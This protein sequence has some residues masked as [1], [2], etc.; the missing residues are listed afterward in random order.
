MLKM[1]ANTYNY[2]ETEDDVDNFRSM[3]FGLFGRNFP[4]TTCIT[5]LTLG[6]REYFPVTGRIEKSVETITEYGADGSSLVKETDFSY[7]PVFL[8]LK[9]VA[10]TNSKGQRLSTRFYYPYDYPVGNAILSMKASGIISP[11]IATEVWLEDAT[12]NWLTNGSIVDYGS[13]GNNIIR[14]SRSYSMRSAAPVPQS[15]IGDFNPALLNRNPQYF[16]PENS[17]DQY[18][19]KGNIAQFETRSTPG[20]IIWDVNG[21]YPVAKVEGAGITSI[22][23]CGFEADGTGNWSVGSVLRNPVGITGSKSYQLVNGTISYNGTL[24]TGAAYT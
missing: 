19:N 18:D 11:T 20:S 9:S 16:L 6:Y 3:K 15:A 23:Y 4:P 8:N 2:I 5:P 12:G 14:P 1:T 17:Y 22:A 13:F 21:Q 10:T 7:D 24:Q